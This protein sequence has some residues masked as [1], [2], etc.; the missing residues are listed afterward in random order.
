MRMLM[1]M[2]AM[3]L[4]AALL[5][6]DMAHAQ[7]GWMNDRNT[8]CKI[9]DDNAGAPGSVTWTGPCVDGLGHGQG[10][11]Q[12]FNG[13]GEPGTRYEGDLVQGRMH[14]RGTYI[15]KSGT[16]YE[17]ELVDGNFHGQ[18]T[19]TWTNGDRYVGAW[20]NDVAHGFG[21]K[22]MADGRVYA[23]QFNDGC[24]K[25]DGRKE[26]DRWATVGRTGEQCG[27]K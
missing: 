2:A 25:D 1:S 15:W 17:G 19:M 26:G 7:A 21:T 11:V 10:V 8:G 16:R 4:A 14:G 3:A 12:L 27:F 5:G 23:G 22:T 24:F 9:W 20:A 18:G 13:N 6:P